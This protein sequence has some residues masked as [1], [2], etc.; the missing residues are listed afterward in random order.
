MSVWKLLGFDTSKIDAGRS[1][2]ASA[3]T[4]TVRKIVKAVDQ[5]EPERAR[6][7]AA[8][9]YLLSRVAHAD[10]QVSPEET[11]A[12]EQIVMQRGGVPEEQAILI[13]QMAKTQSLLFSGTENFL[14][15][16]EFGKIAD[17]AQKLAMLDCLYAVCAADRRISVVEDNEIR[18]I[19]M[20]LQLSHDE[21]ITV[22]LNYRDHL[23]VLK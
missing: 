23:A 1:P 4:E 12:M 15:T 14:V 10:Q 9:A 16:R 18:K 22:R 13:V 7:I 21:F 6:Y 11:Q 5:M 20:E 17:H 8:F 3:E 19:S 2:A